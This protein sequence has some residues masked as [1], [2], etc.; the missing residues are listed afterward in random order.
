MTWTRRQMV[1]MVAAPGAL[2]ALG[3]AGAGWL[4]GCA[5]QGGTAPQGT[6]GLAEGP[7]KVTLVFPGSATDAEDYKAVADAM[8]KKYPKIDTGVQQQLH[9]P[10]STSAGSTRSWPTSR[11][12]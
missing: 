9:S 2:A 4:A 1:R 7:A 8:T 12:A 10:A 6:T 11:W 3:V 5:C